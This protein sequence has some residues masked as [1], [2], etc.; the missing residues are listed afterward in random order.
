M[1]HRN[2]AVDWDAMGR[3][4]PVPCHALAPGQRRIFTTGQLARGLG[5]HPNA[6]AGL[7][8]RGF[9]N[10]PDARRDIDSL[11]QMLADAEPD[12]V[13]PMV[14]QNHKGCRW[15]LRVDVLGMMGV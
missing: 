2:D 13:R 12:R 5:R 1:P 11:A 8:R 14:M 15:A 9:R 10:D 7:L 6:V 4:E 3:G